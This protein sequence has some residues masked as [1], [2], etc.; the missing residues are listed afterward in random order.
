MS[1][2]LRQIDRT[3]NY[4]I[5]TMQKENPQAIAH[6]EAI[7]IYKLPIFTRPELAAYDGVHKP[8][9]YVAIKGFIYDVSSNS[10]NYGQGKSY[11]KLV[12]KDLTRLLGT[13][14]LTTANGV[15]TWSV[16]GLTEKQ[17]QSI[18]KWI[19]FF[20]K[21]YPIVGVVVSHES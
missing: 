19:D 3:E 8:Q 6:N 1:E 21:R 14:K 4:Q 17:H 7:D 18:D 11:H 12:A 15:Q 2:K 16:D 5:L 13:N 20:K 9:I 10:K